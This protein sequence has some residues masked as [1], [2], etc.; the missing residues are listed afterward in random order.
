MTSPNPYRPTL[1]DVAAIKA[2]IIAALDLLGNCDERQSADVKRCMFS[3]ATLLGRML[4][5]LEP[6]K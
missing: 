1:N 5:R 4:E 6:T 2:D 3:I